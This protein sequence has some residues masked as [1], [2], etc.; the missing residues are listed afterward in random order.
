[1]LERRAA[2]PTALV[3]LL[4]MVLQGT[5]RHRWCL[6]F[7]KIR[8]TVFSRHSLAASVVCQGFTS[9]FLDVKCVMESTEGMTPRWAIF[10]QHYPT[11]S[12]PKFTGWQA[13]WYSISNR[14]L[15]LLSSWLLLTNRASIWQHIKTIG[16]RNFSC[17]PGT[18]KWWLLLLWWQY[19][20]V[21]AAEKWTK[22]S[23][24]LNHESSPNW[25][26]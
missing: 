5:H 23:L 3:V 19:N 10:H 18:L 25:T 13:R 12:H 17:A 14:H 8:G 26:Q 2:C 6:W 9:L 24:F 7:R 20:M 21:L 16:P 22:T 11:I 15:N 4:P 1:M